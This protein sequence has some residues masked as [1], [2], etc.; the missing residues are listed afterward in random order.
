MSKPNENSVFLG[1]GNEWSHTQ[2]QLIYDITKR[3]ISSI[4]GKQRVTKGKGYIHGVLD[5][6]VNICYD[7]SWADGHT[8]I[9]GATGSGK[10]RFFDLVLKQLILK[11]SFQFPVGYKVRYHKGSAH[12]LISECSHYYG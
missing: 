3:D 2:A 5:K 12:P 9:A 8:L 1:W 7:L 11:G 6:E 10:T 4:I